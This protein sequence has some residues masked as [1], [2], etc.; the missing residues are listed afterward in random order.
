MA[1]EIRAGFPRSTDYVGSPRWQWFSIMLSFLITLP[2][3]GV[4]SLEMVIWQLIFSSLYLD[5]SF[6]QSTQKRF[7]MPLVHL[8]LSH[9]FFSNL[10]SAFS[11][12]ICIGMRHS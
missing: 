2:H 12:T 6:T 5:L 8:Y 7:A 3:T 1:I 4:F 10:S 9:C 11:D